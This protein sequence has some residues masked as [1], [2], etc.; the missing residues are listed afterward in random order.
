[1]EKCFDGMQKKKKTFLIKAIIIYA[2]VLYNSTTEE[3]QH[4]D[5]KHNSS[6]EN[7]KT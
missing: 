7:I 3:P 1:M 4:R 5:K 6:L 2:E